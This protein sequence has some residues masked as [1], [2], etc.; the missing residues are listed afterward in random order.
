MHE[1][2]LTGSIL[3]CSRTPRSR[4]R[5]AGLPE[6]VP[7]CAGRIDEFRDPSCSRAKPCH[8]EC[9]DTSSSLELATGE[10]NDVSEDKGFQIA[11]TR[12]RRWNRIFWMGILGIFFGPILALVIAVIVYQ[13]AGSNY[14]APIGLS[15]PLWSVAAL[16]LALLVRS[17]RKS[18][19]RTWDL[20]QVA[21]QLGM[22][23]EVDPNRS[24]YEF[25]KSVSLMQDPLDCKGSN[26]VQGSAN[27]ISFLALD[28]RYS[29]FYGTV[30]LIGEQTL[31][32][33]PG[34]VNNELRF[35]IVPVGW[36][37]QMADRLTGASA[38][39]Y[40]HN[41]EFVRRFYVVSD[42]DSVLPDIFSDQFVELFLREPKLTLVVEQGRVMV[43]LQGTYIP[44]RQYQEFLRLA[45][46]IVEI[47]RKA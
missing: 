28:Y 1:T 34:Q 11:R 3:H 20:A 21:Q 31:A 25:L 39:S 8:T 45:F 36:A 29:Y 4:H 44:A 35:A 42:N 38:N 24:S 15:S 27:S 23:F 32:V 22:N 10:E 26:L 37:D 19:K 12:F 14:S 41:P 40:H 43:F 33:F 13:L 47:I 7:H 17:R 5:K 16:A 46:Q 30:S 2:S 9:V 18:A 6:P